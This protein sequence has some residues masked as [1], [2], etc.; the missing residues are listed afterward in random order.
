[1]EDLPILDGLTET[2]EMAEPIM[3]RVMKLL[4]DRDR[5]SNDEV[6]MSLNAL[7]RAYEKESD[8]EVRARYGR[9]VMDLQGMNDDDHKSEA[10]RGDSLG[11]RRSRSAHP[12]A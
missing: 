12:A 9:I 10:G 3:F 2:A 5:T 8:P 1:M 4:A 7:E 11:V 6:R